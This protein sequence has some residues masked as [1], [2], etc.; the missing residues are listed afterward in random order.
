MTTLHDVARAA[1]VSKSTVSNVIR[2]GAPVAD[3][4]RQRVE[5]AIAQLGYT[6]NAIARSLRARASHTLGVI[7]PDP[8]NPF[9]AQLVLGAERA[10]HD[11]GYA[12]LIANTGFDAE[13]E[14]GALR[15]L[16]ARRVDGVVVAGVS[17]TS[18]MHLRLLERSIPVVFAGCGDP[19]D[20]RAGVVDT[21]DETAMEEVVEHLAGLGHRRLAFVP[22][23][24]GEM[25]VDRRE[26]FFAA[27]I[28]RRGLRLVGI[29]ADPSAIAAHNDTLAIETIDRLERAGR[30]VPGDVS[31]VGFD[32]IPLARHQRID[33]T[34]VRSDG[35]EIG[36]RATELLAEAVREQRFV[37]TREV[38]PAELV[39]RGSTA[40]A[41]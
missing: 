6:P 4:T 41:A 10:A 29:G 18:E 40:R 15:A 33:L 26:L 36:R 7:V 12:M 1:G 3:E 23:D 13:F 22:Q 37:A 8:A 25:S 28:R 14:E 35:R 38:H 5:S 30:H 9:Y 17:R 11:D 16:I 19:E 2:G 34:T 27:A 20:D 21:D 32:D 24:L 31:V 39:V